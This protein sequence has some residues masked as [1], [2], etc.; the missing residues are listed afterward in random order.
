MTNPTGEAQ[1]LINELLRLFDT[2]TV[3]RLRLYRPNLAQSTGVVPSQ[4]LPADGDTGSGYTPTSHASAHESGGDDPLDLGSLAGALTDSQHGARSGG[5]L[6]SVATGASPGFMSST[7][8]TKLDGIAAGAQPG[9]VTS[10]GLT[11]PSELTVANS[12]ISSAGSIAL[13]W[14]SQAINQVFA[15]PGSGL[16]GA[17][18]FRSLVAADIPNLDAGKITTGQLASQRGGTGVDNGGRTL[19]IS[20]NGGTLAFSAASS[21]LTIPA[22]GTA[23]LLATQQTFSERNRF[24]YNDISDT[25]SVLVHPSSGNGSMGFRLSNDANYVFFSFQ[26]ASGGLEGY[27]T[28][29]GTSSPFT[30]RAGSLEFGTVNSRNIDFRPNDTLWMRLLGSGGMEL[31]EQTAPSAGAANTAR[32]FVRDNGAGKTQL[33]VIFNTGAIQ[34][35]ATQP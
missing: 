10:V 26:N 9:T 7:D 19:T 23:A 31:Y 1:T 24:S 34:V 11:A 8:K 5:T 12:P 33:C 17:P 18:G 25:P 27:F 32:L 20:T 29:I 21:T 28:F 6:H 15:S 14:A 3:E 35:I 4:Q 30:A 2:K 22:T 16:S 13:T